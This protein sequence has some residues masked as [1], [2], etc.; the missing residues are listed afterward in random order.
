MKSTAVLVAGL[1]ASAQGFAPATQGRVT[2]T[3]LSESLFDKIFGMDLFAPVKD[4]NE[5]GARSRKNVSR[6]M[7]SHLD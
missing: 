6:K 7:A 3:Q 5:Y 1:V 2:G 4:Q